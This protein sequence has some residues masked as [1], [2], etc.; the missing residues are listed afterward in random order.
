MNNAYPINVDQ[1]V[2]DW[3]RTNLSYNQQLMERNTKTIQPMTS[4]F[5]YHDP[6]NSNIDQKINFNS[7][8]CHL[9]SLQKQHAPYQKCVCNEIFTNVDYLIDQN[10]QY[11]Q[12]QVPQQV[13]QQFTQ[14]LT[15]NHKFYCTKPVDFEDKD[16]L[17]TNKHLDKVNANHTL[18]FQNK[19]QTNIRT[20]S[21]YFDRHAFNT[22]DSSGFVVH[23]LDSPSKMKKN[24]VGDDCKMSVNKTPLGL[25]IGKNKESKSL[26]SKFTS[27][28]TSSSNDTN[29][30]NNSNININ[31]ITNSSS[32]T[33]LSNKKS[34]IKSKITSFWKRSKSAHEK[35]DQ[36]AQKN[37]MKGHLSES[38]DTKNACL[39][40]TP[41]ISA[42]QSMLN[43]LVP[44]RR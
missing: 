21:K 26:L 32:T 19:G 40:A 41:T 7:C 33:K 1:S 6:M 36:E 42:K 15:R 43:R 27:P 44:T 25:N 14:S 34:E 37:K 13:P 3:K 16:L 35:L 4:N 12:S 24:I 39:T 5:V 18:Y 8:R 38:D 11:Y 20:A 30:N 29:I 10:Q 22:V 17:F 28:F 2:N 23:M 31:S 9:Q